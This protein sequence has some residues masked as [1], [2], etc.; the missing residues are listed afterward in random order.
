VATQGACP[1][2]RVLDDDLI[3][4]VG[5]RVFD[6]PCRLIFER[7]SKYQPPDSPIVAFG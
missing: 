4:R 2:R 5:L 1:S 6:N 7:S 3:P